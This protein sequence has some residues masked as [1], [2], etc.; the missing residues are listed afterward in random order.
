MFPE[1]SNYQIL[2]GEVDLGPRP[3][4]LDVAVPLLTLTRALVTDQEQTV[5]LMNTSLIILDWSMWVTDTLGDS[6]GAANYTLR[7]TQLDVLGN[8]I[9]A[10]EEVQPTDL[11]S[12]I[13]VQLDPATNQYYVL[14]SEAYTSAVGGEDPDRAIY[15][16]EACVPQP[17]ESEQCY[18]SNITAYA[19]G[20][21]FRPLSE[22]VFSWVSQYLHVDIIIRTLRPIVTGQIFCPDLTQQSLHYRNKF[23]PINTF[24]G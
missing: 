21:D 4:L 20:L 15:E 11:E 14:I 13:I 12:R 1:T 6:A 3:E 5:I 24:A 10:P 16:L 19:I 7:K 17:D 2:I 9:R 22:C 8:P 23:L 18:E